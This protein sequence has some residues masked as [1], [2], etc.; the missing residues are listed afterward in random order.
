MPASKKIQICLD[1]TASLLG[2]VELSALKWEKG[3]S[4]PQTVYETIPRHCLR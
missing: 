4:W 3:P 2:Q 1:K